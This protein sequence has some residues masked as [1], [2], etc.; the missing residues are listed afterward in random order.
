VRRRRRVPALLLALSTFAF[1]G[2]LCAFQVTGPTAAPRLLGRLAAA[3]FE[4]DRWTPQHREELG[5]VAADR[6]RG[7][8]EVKGLPV[9]VSV[10]PA[11]VLSADGSALGRAIATAAGERL[12]DEGRGA[13]TGGGDISMTSPE[14]WAISM[15][16]KS[17]HDAWRAGL[18]AAS[19]MAL[20]AF[21][22][23][24]LTSASGL[25]GA[26]RAATVGAAAFAAVAAASWLVAGLGARIPDAPAD[27]ELMRMLRDC[28][29]LGLRNGL[30]LTAAGAAL[31]LALRVLQQPG[32][33]LE[34]WPAAF[35]EPAP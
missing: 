32:P 1:L 8:V 30:A 10:P 12:Y 31:V 4:L 18:A 6:T 9:E 5:T 15:L 17:S 27:S 23:C 11:D 14:R 16:D 7:L 24:A 28:A 25:A 22:L 3:L 21:A 20:A 29:W 19:V 35:D 2:A 13:F 34:E 33:A 26:L